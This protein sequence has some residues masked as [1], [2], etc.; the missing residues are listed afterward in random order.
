MPMTYFRQFLRTRLPLLLCILSLPAQAQLGGLPGGRIPIAVPVL[1]DTVQQ[2]PPIVRDRVSDLTA[3]ARTQAVEQLLRRHPD[4]IDLDVRGAPVV[5]SEVVA[6]DPTGL[7]LELAREA[8]F[9]I[10]EVRTLEA[11]GLRVVVLRGPDGIATAA[12][13]EQ[14]RRLDPAGTYDFNHLYFGSGG[15]VGGSAPGPVASA[16]ADA[17]L[18][19]GLIDSGVDPDH[20]ALAGVDVQRWGCGGKPV[21]DGHG[22]A[23]ASLLVGNERSRAAAGSTLFAADIYC[24]R[25][26]GGAVVGFAEAMAWLAKQDVGVINLS[27]VG[28]HNVLLQ[29]ATAALAASGRVLVAAVGND[30][31][32]SPPLFPAAYADVIGVTAV[33]PRGRALPE[34]V[35]GS[36]VDFAARGSELP[37]A[38]YGGGWT[39]VRGTS[40]AAP[41]VARAA[42]LRMREPGNTQ[43]KRIRE[44]LVEMA[45]DLGADG[46]DDIYGFGLVEATPA[47]AAG[48]SD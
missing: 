3:V 7:A 17:A 19:V 21:G 35:R 5:R 9:G 24:G 47:V 10:G 38:R 15:A 1:R 27:L 25:A 45:R 46:R 31:P 30:G 28:P 41:L 32:A 4:L 42:A 20:P 22:T 8:G 23:V 33:D 26:T 12:A 37:A 40:F 34:A 16:S 39:K 14:L 11:L 2:V 13:L 36:Q 44:G 43:A 29:R 48:G 18:R 6:I